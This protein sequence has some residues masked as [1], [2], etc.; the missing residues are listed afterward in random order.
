MTVIAPE[1]HAGEQQWWSVRFH[2]P[3]GQPMR[4]D[5][6]TTDCPEDGRRKAVTR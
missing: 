3:S 4:A 6:D 5:D 2:I 1:R